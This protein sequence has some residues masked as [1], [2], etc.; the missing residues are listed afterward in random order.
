MALAGSTGVH[1]VFHGFLTFRESHHLVFGH[2]APEAEEQGEVI[3]QATRIHHLPILPMIPT[4]RRVVNQRRKASRQQPQGLPMLLRARPRR[5]HCHRC[6][7]RHLLL[8]VRL[9]Q[10]PITFSLV[11]LERLLLAPVTPVLSFQDAV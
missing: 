2:S 4:L 11:H 8:H 7:R 9:V 1:R 6:H 3:H 10:S 5:H